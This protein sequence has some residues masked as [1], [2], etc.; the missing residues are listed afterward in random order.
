MEVF[1][2]GTQLLFMVLTE[3]S[4]RLT[5]VDSNRWVPVDVVA[6]E[7]GK[8]QMVKIDYEVVCG[9]VDLLADP[10]PVVYVH[11]NTEKPYEFKAEPPFR[12]LN[13]QVGVK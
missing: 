10:V 9:E 1:D 8:P 7:D 13:M 12:V 4:G 3:G 11:P 5:V 2:P 6:R